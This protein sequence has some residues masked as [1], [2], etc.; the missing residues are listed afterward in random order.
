MV[1]INKWQSIPTVFCLRIRYSTCQ[2]TV[3]MV[4]DGWNVGS[5]TSRKSTSFLEHGSITSKERKKNMLKFSSRTHCRAVRRHHDHHGTTMSF[6]R[7]V[8]SFI[9]LP[10]NPPF[11][12]FHP[13]SFFTHYTLN[14]YFSQKK[15]IIR[16]LF[17]KGLRIKHDL[18]HFNELSPPPRMLERRGGGF[19]SLAQFNASG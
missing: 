16:V 11:L 14:A 12:F 19:L 2:C 5:Q 15:I 17:E 13:A 7:L 1:D 3:A 18:Y 6:R 8:Q 4:T 9:I 10:G